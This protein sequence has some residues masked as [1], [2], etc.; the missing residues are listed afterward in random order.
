MEFLDVRDFIVLIPLVDRDCAW[1]FERASLCQRK[2][3]SSLVHHARRSRTQRYS[4]ISL[5]I[6]IEV[7]SNTFWKAFSPLT[8]YH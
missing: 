5:L 3:N 6:L 2:T 1:V 8:S 4:N 7:Y